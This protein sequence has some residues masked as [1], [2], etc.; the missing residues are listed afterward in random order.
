MVELTEPGWGTY[1]LAYAAMG[2]AVLVKGPIGVVLPTAVIG[3]F[4]LCT[5]GPNSLSCLPANPP[6]GSRWAWLRRLL[7][8]SLRLLSPAHF[9]R[10]VYGMR[11]VT[12]LAA[13][14]LVAGPWYVWVGVRTDWRWP[15]LFFGE[16]NF[17]RFVSAMDNH[18]G[19]IVYY[20]GAILVLF[21]PWSVILLASLIELA[22]RAARTSGDRAGA[23]L[24][25]AWL[26]VYLGFFSLASTKLPN[27]IIPC[28]P[29]LALMTALFVERWIKRPQSVPRA[30]PWIAF[31]ILGLAGAGIAV[32]TPIAARVL[33][34]PDWTLGL[35]GLVPLAGALAGMWFT[36]RCDAVR[37]VRSLGITSAAFALWVFGVTVPQADRFQNSQA[38]VEMIDELSA[39]P[40]RVASFRY[41][42]PSMVFYGHQPVT[43]LRAAEDVAAFFGEHPRDAFL[44]TLDE[45]LPA[46]AGL[47]PGDVTVLESHRRLF[48]SGKILLLGRASD[49]PRWPSGAQG[50]HR[51]GEA[52]AAADAPRR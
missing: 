25:A 47:L 1:A 34:E 33:V 50:Q 11:P 35:A 22:M 28:Y 21:F 12:A 29:A 39:G 45:Q 48:K 9:L 30:W 5:R 6:S 37:A 24:V 49:V 52:G 14:L 40:A 38:F 36:W 32:A 20:L 15:A 8:A 44:Y 23:I 2:A 3:L 17:G 46:L 31:G 41:F 43:K 7:D 4:L 10:T 13:V 42:R 18:R 27:Y 16:Q 26:V 19:P 51:L